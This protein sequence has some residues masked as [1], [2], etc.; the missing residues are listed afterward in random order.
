MNMQ[1]KGSEKD[2]LRAPLKKPEDDLNILSHRILNYAN[3]VISRI[4]F[5]REVSKILMSFSGCDT[6]ELWLKKDNGYSHCK[7]TQQAEHSFQY[8]TLLPAKNREG[9]PSHG[10]REYSII[11]C[12][13]TNFLNGNFDPSLH[14]FTSG[15][16]FWTGNTEETLTGILKLKGKENLHACSKDTDYKSLA[17]IP[18]VFGDTNIGLMQ[19]M[20]KQR[21]YFTEKEI[22][23]Y[24]GIAASVGIALINQRSQAALRE[25]VKELTCLYDISRLADQEGKSHGEILQAIVD[26]I[27][28][29]WQYPEITVGRITLDGYSYA[30]PGFRQGR[31]KQVADVIVKGKQRGIIEV[32][33]TKTKPVLDEGPFLK[34]ER[35]L[36]EAV[37]RQVALII[38]RKEARADSFK[39]Q[40]QLR[41]A[42][43]LATIG[44]LAAG[45]AH[46]L[47]EPLGNILGFAQ[48]IKKYPALPHDVSRDND[49]IINAS[50]HAREVIKKLMIF[51]RQ[52]PSRIAGVQLNQVVK[53]GLYFFEAR[54][55]KAGIELVL[56]LSAGIPEITGDDAQ[57][58]Q[59]LVNLVVN[60]IQA[61]PEGGRLTIQTYAGN[62]YV[63][64][65][66]EDTGTGMSE[67]TVK[68]IFIPFFTTKDINEGTGLGLAVVH[69]I[70]TSHKGTTKVES[71][72]GQGT[73]FEVQLPITRP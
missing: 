29:A 46:E 33:Y 32:V 48:L 66:V 27:P 26:F 20:S 60:S 1:K 8:E 54:C 4:D 68:K 69:G 58:N 72:V 22:G 13:R 59:V 43:R 12:L 24:E 18:L 3:C 11:D 19:L 47:N 5:L 21:G 23:D 2:E 28:S 56:S 61:M 42:D 7:I 25:R 45:V 50:L 49:K 31:R 63:F 64:L 44:Q 73:R 6:V 65:V 57:L 52:M 51:A 41:H 15:G 39:L 37:S 36:L 55:A 67:D 17:L 34:E 40:E 30:T 53:E 35:S 9:E 62:D 14:P 71:R 70:V 38:E 10:Q 16:S